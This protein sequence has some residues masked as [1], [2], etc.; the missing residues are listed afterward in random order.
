MRINCVP[1]EE[2][3]RLH[4]I[5]EMREIKMLPKALLRT[6]NSKRGLDKSR[7]PKQYTLNQGHGYFFYDKLGYIYDR[8]EALKNEMAR[9]G[10]QCNST[11]IVKIDIPELVNRWTP[12]ERDV[13]VNRE[14]INLR[15][16]QKPWLY[17]K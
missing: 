9:R 10:Y 13:A 1:V 15:I 2:L 3:H 5:A 16:S 12:T 11:E 6:I 8:F 7:I 4:L 17:A 14:R